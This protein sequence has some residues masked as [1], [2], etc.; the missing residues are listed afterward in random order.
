MT[1]SGVDR[2]RSSQGVAARPTAIS[3]TPPT[4]HRARAVCTDRRTS[5]RS[6][7][8]KYWEIMT[9]APEDRPTKKPMIRLMMVLVVPP[10][11]E[12]AAV[13]TNRPTT[14]ASAVL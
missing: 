8:P 9:V 2:A 12:R 14:M 3:A 6:P 5:P 7:P 11:A 1:S 4:R 13:P 10:T